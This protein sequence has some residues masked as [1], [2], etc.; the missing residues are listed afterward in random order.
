[1]D[2]KKLLQLILDIAEEML[3][4]GAEVSRVEDSIQRMC[5]AYGFIEERTNAFI[6]TSNIQV[7]A[8][9]PD[10]EVITQIRQ[11]VR[12]DINYDRLDYLN[13]LS[14]KI[15]SKRYSLE[16]IREMYDAVMA[17]PGNPLPF[18]LLGRFCAAG[19]FTVFF[20]GSIADGVFAGLAGI[21]VALF[22]R[23]MDRI[24]NNVLAKTFLASI[25]SGFLAIGLSFFGIHAD[26]IMIGCIM[27]LIPGIALTN[28]IRDML[29][30]DIASG[31]LRFFNSLLIAVVIA[32][33]F[34]IPILFVGKSF[35][36]LHSGGSYYG[37]YEWL[38]Q[39]ASALIGSYGF[40]VFFNMKGRQVAYAAVSGCATWGVYLAAVHFGMEG[41]FLPT[42]IAS[43]FAGIVS[44]RLAVINRAPATIFLTASAITLIPGSSLY[45]AMSNLV[46]RN[47]ENFEFYAQRAVSTALAIAL[48]FFFVALFNKYLAL[49][50]KS[51]R[52]RERGE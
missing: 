44:D 22:L 51:G 41:V 28:S 26:K 29:I 8:E 35:M 34:A 40:A 24:D 14:R 23:F 20:G 7:A 47:M 19:G 15:C 43:I 25:L 49:A 16:E 33:G 17:R 36:L 42:L 27:L 30:G 52:K 39:L 31:L 18:Y 1:M 45:Y 2:Y 4:A 5:A 3:V 13:D 21:L 12:S 50:R 6:I 10:G 37:E 32:C 46:S 11:V 9:S 48:G 38:V